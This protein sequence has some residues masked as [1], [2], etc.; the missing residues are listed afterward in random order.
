M[1]PTFNPW[2]GYFDLIDQSDVFVIYDDVQLSKQSW[3][4]RNRIK[5]AQG[6]L[7]LNIPHLKTDNWRELLICD[8]KTNELLP[9]R[10]KHLKSIENSY[11]KAE[12]F[13]E[14]FSFVTELYNPIFDT[15]SAFNTNIIKQISNR[16]GI[17]NNFIQSSCLAD[18]EGT[19]DLRLLNICKTLNVTDYLSPQGSSS[20]I[21]EF[22]PGGELAKGGINVWYH[23]YKPIQYL[24]VNG[25]FIPKLGIFDLLFNIG[26]NNSLEVIRAGRLNSISYKNFKTTSK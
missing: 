19:K 21:E 13:E 22:S 24:Q 18:L 6:D 25:D 26:F 12:H 10:K 23:N 14:I 11:K 4:V 16:V 5:T 9:W 1:Q 3:Q 8:A 15:V 2:L 17:K 7:F 20:Y